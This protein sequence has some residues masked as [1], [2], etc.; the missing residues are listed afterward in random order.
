MLID[1][2]D[3][4]PPVKERPGARFR[5]VAAGLIVGIMS[6]AA[7]THAIDN[8]HTGA[9]REPAA[10]SPKVSTST[11]SVDVDTL[12]AAAD[13]ALTSG[14]PNGTLVVSNHAE[15]LSTNN[16]VGM[17][18]SGAL[19]DV[20]H[21]AASY[22]MLV[23]CAGRGRVLAILRVGADIDDTIVNCEAVPQPARLSLTSAGGSVEV[24]LTAVDDE[25][26]AVSYL[27]AT[28]H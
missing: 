11:P 15:V 19:S 18:E 16:G 10:A 21:P 28:N 17:R 22:S 9:P 7:V 3:P 5:W 8:S 27:I 6:T 14:T 4:A 25:T 26:V 20:K 23:Y 2:T 12:R 1:L 24:R 13:R